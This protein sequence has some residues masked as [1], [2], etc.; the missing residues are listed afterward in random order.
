[1]ARAAWET[2]LDRVGQV[3]GKQYNRVAVVMCI[4]GRPGQWRRL[5]V[6]A[7]ATP[8]GGDPVRVALCMRLAGMPCGRRGAGLSVA[9]GADGPEEALTPAVPRGATPADAHVGDG[10]GATDRGAYGG[11][12][13][14]RAGD[15]G[16]T[17]LRPGPRD[18]LPSD[19]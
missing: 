7:R 9:R 18:L 11:G 1:G 8:H 3:A 6:E 13:G 5:R 10:G 4:V 16:G 15:G 19:V 2:G 17:T 12:A 14:I